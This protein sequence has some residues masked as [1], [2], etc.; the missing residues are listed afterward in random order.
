MNVRLVCICIG[1]GIGLITS[2]PARAAEIHFGVA[3]ITP[4]ETARLAA[5]CSDESPSPTVPPGSCDVTFIFHDRAGRILKQSTMTLPPGT[6]GSLDLRGSEIGAVRR[7]EIVPCIK[8]ASGAAFGNVQIFDNFLQRTRV[9]TNYAERLQVRTGELHTGRIGITPFDTARLNA[10]CPSDPARAG[11]GEACDVTFIFHDNAG[12]IFKQATMT[13][14]P[15]KAGFLD[16]RAAE[17]GLTA[18]R[19]EVDP[20][21]RVGRG[22]AIANFEMIDTLTGLTLLL[23]NPAAPMTP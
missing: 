16:L 3:G 8:V 6:G 15:G 4:I 7:G 13:L 22:G 23:A 20:C 18:R 14:L 12:R 17:T 9:L 21:I 5:F 10:F 11:G 1:I 2:I 19:V